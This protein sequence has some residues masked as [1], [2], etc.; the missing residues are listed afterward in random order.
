MSHFWKNQPLT[1]ANE[2]Y[3]GD[4][5]IEEELNID[6]QKLDEEYIWSELDLNE[7]KTRIEVASFLQNYYIE[8]EKS[9]FKIYYTSEFLKWNYVNKKYTPK[10]TI[11]IKLKTNNLLVGFIG[12]KKVK[13][14]INRNI[15]EMIEVNFLCVHSLLRKK[16]YAEKLIKELERRSLAEEYKHSIFCSTKEIG[17]S[18]FTAEYYH[19][20][21]NVKKLVDT[22]FSKIEGNITMDDLE[23]TYELKEKNINKNFRELEPRHLES[24]YKKFNEYNKRYFIHPV[25]DLE[26]FKELFYDN[27][28]VKT[29]VIEN[30]QNN[31]EIIDMIS[32]FKLKRVTKDNKFINEGYLYYY[33]STIETSFLLIKDMMISAKREGIDLITGSDIMENSRPFANLNFVK[34]SKKLNYYLL[35]WRCNSF[36]KTQIGKIFY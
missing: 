18:I 27:E 5:L 4:G 36:K 16:G 33:T 3:Y 13:I 21:L 25:I 1:K 10:L 22:D 15:L 17:K 26:E 6:E 14:Q 32:Y 28:V 34:V 11:G 31:E 24:A 29:Y 2:C 7:E 35:N 19:R 9:K 20:A 23:R 30:F 8:D 12:G